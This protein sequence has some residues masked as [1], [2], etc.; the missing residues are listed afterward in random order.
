MTFPDNKLL[1][2]LK[3][4]KDKLLKLDP[5]VLCWPGQEMC[6]FVMELCSEMILLDSLSSCEVRERNLLLCHVVGKL[7]FVLSTH[8]L[9]MFL[10]HLF[11][12]WILPVR[13]LL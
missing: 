11:F 6:R 5:V 1:R 3:D 10:F 13:N 2:E 12:K 8:S 7:L 4:V 9:Q